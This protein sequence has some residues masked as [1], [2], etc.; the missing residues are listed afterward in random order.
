MGSNEGRTAIRLL[1]PDGKPVVPA[2]STRHDGR[3]MG[4]TLL[5]VPVPKDE[6]A[7]LLQLAMRG[8]PRQFSF[9]M[10]AADL[11]G[12]AAVLRPNVTYLLRGPV[13]FISPQAGQ[14][15]PIVFDFTTAAVATIRLIDNEGAEILTT[16]IAKG[17]QRTEATVTA[18]P[19]AHPFPWILDIHGAAQVQVKEVEFLYLSPDKKG[20]AAILE[21]LKTAK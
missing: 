8:G 17:L 15:K 12:E 1:G 9:F 5:R 3:Y 20:L 11:D 2:L 13:Y 7:G 18:D 19:K 14:E 16:S 6:K 4:A 21:A 10:P